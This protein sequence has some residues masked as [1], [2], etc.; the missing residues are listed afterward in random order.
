MATTLTA[1][2]K[3]RRD[4]ASNWTSQDPTLLAG[5]LG[6]ESDTKKYKIGDG[7]TAWT[8]L[9]YIPIPDTNRLLAGNLT[10]GGNLTVSGSTTTVSSSTLTVTD[11]N[12]ELA[13]VATPTDTTADQGG[14]TL[15]G[16][17]NKTILWSDSSD[18]WDFNQHV[19]L[20]STF[21]FK[22]N[23]VSVLSA[24][25]LGSTVVNSSLTSVGTISSGTWQ[26]STVAVDQG[27][28]GQTSYTNGQ[29]LIGNT[30]GNTLAK[31]TLTGGTAITVTNGGGSIEISSTAVT[32]VTG[33]SPIVSSGGATPAISISGASGSAAGSMS[34]SHY[35][36][37]E[38]IEASADVTDAT[39]VAAAG[40]AMKSTI[41]AKAD[42][43]VGTADNAIDRLA[44]GTNNY[45]LTADSSEATGLKWAE[46]PG[47]G[48]TGGGSDKVF[49]ENQQ[50]ATTS[51]SITS[52]SNAQLV[53]A[54]SLNSSCTIT[55]PSTSILLIW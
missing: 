15:L 31:G 49:V 38:G 41:D 22:I 28:S 3:N 20:A 47:G 36:K 43:L 4:T 9:D 53:G 45:V 24:T 16:A 39:N 30:T 17:T 54:L 23:N 11:K 21:E 29:L 52:G 18:S 37:L 33:T 32:G 55:V 1:L 40:A 46:A 35:T 50:T 44:V 13:K 27:G 6:V 34:S 2:I 51:Y 42:L 25:T 7:S 19:N 12:I 8:S 10:V 5:E 14:I 48:A 26:G